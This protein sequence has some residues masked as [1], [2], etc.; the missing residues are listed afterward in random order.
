MTAGDLEVVRRLIRT[1]LAALERRVATQVT[2]GV[3]ERVDD[4]PTQAL[5]VT[6]YPGDVLPVE[7]LQPYGL[8]AHPPTGAQ[9]LIV[10][11]GGREHAVAISCDDR[12]YRPAG[13]PAH[14]TVLYDARGNR[15]QLGSGSIKVLPAAGGVV[16]L[17]AGALTAANGVVHGQAVD[18]LTGL[19]YAQLGAASQTVLAEG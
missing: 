10:C 1:E 6:G 14:D 12:R 18:P 11:V 8:S 2:R 4:T 9:A 13:L 19:T 17:G 16:M 7:H 5:Q 15:V 3:V